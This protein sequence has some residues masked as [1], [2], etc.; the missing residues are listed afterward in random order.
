MVRS[1]GA[2]SDGSVV[3]MGVIGVTTLHPQGSESPEL[4]SPLARGCITLIE[5]FLVDGVHR[6]WPTVHHSYEYD[7]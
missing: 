2:F 1:A 5:G 7:I 4:P 6:R 3:V